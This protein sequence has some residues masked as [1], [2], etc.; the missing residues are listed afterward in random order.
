MRYPCRRGDGMTKIAISYRRDDSMD[1]TGRIFDRLTSRYGRDAV[2][3]DIDSIPPGMRFREHLQT[4]LD[5]SDVLMVVVGPRWIGETGRQAAGSNPRPTTCGR[6]SRSLSIGIFPSSPCWLAVP[7]MPEPSELPENIRN[8]AYR[9]AVEIDSGRDFD[10][11]ISGLIRGDGQPLHGQTPPQP[12]RSRAGLARREPST[13]T[14]SRRA[15]R[16]GAAGRRQREP[17]NL[18][19]QVL[20]GAM[21]ALGLVHSVWFSINVMI[22]MDG[23]ALEE[24]LRSIWMLCGSDL[25]H[26]RS[27]CRHR[28]SR[29]QSLGPLPRHRRSACC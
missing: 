26:W 20:G 13:G 28:H 19:L 15:P 5:G 9:N 29:W 6:S 16:R 11:H 18:V 8:F 23:G 25:R 4:A 12:A 14:P 10:H 27:R 21:L 1:I 17:G 24:L 22:A 7:E 2:F 3:R